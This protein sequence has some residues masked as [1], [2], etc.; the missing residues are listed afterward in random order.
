[1][2]QA[3]RS[4][5]E[6]VFKLHNLTSHPALSSCLTDAHHAALAGAVKPWSSALLKVRCSSPDVHISSSSDEMRTAAE[7]GAAAAPTNTPC[8]DLAVYGCSVEQQHFLER[9]MELLVAG[10]AES[11]ARM[12]Q[13]RLTD[14]R[15]VVW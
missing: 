9:C 6:E 13:V 15:S 8:L 1:M 2:Q 10:A 7:T 14:T 5:Q 4:C 11:N 12:M 3:C